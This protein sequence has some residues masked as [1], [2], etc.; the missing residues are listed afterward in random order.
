MK[1]KTLTV[2]LV[3]L[4]C[5]RPQLLKRCLLTVTRQTVKPMEVL[6]VNGSRR[7]FQETERVCDGF[8]PRL[9]LTKINNTRHHTTPFGRNLANQ[10]AHGDLIV[11][12]DDDLAAHPRYLE[13][14]REH[15]QKNP[16]LSAVMGHIKN[17]RPTNIY[18]AVQYSY[19]TKGIRSMLDAPNR[20]QQLR[21][22]RMFDCEAMAIRR[23]VIQTVGFPT[24]G[25]TYYRNEDVELGLT[26]LEQGNI[27]WFDPTITAYA[28]P[29][30]RLWP[31]LTTAYWN[32]YSDAWTTS[33]VHVD[34]KTL[35]YPMAFIPWLL[36]EI[37]AAKQFG[38]VQKLAYMMV[39]LVFPLVSR[40]GWYRYII[41]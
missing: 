39:L 11:Y 8:S 22:G 21:L 26:L 6:V 7:L 31:F 23:S 36:N 25:P 3:I 19:Y 15:F 5:D 30:T 37:Q 41:R 14:F 40:I 9:P 33:H 38:P 16:R 10:K 24:D 35:P 1:H 20:I 2:S 32:G 27:V 29:R 18:A 4:T 17:A 34:I 12:L 13:K 28:V